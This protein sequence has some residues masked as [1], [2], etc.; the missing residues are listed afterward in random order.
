MCTIL[1]IT[2]DSQISVLVCFYLLFICTSI[3]VCPHM[4]IVLIITDDSQISVLVWFH[5][6]YWCTNVTQILYIRFS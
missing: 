1:I 2:D 4:C 3:Y 6:F 5:L